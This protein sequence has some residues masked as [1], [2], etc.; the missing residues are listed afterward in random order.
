MKS[1]KKKVIKKGEDHRVWE[2]DK[3]EVIKQ[4]VK[5]LSE[6]IKEN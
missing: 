2:K 1:V 6:K 3:R 4:E 5:K